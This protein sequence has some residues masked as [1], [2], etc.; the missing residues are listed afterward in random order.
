MTYIKM[1]HIQLLL[2]ATLLAV[3]LLP[4]R[5][6][7][8]P[9]SIASLRSFMSSSVIPPSTVGILLHTSLHRDTSGHSFSELAEALFPY[10][11]LTDGNARKLAEEFWAKKAVP[12]FVSTKSDH[13]STSR[14][15]TSC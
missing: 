5:L 4:L 12:N 10:A 14:L 15:A 11:P 7:V 2:M 1:K 8:L 6:L 3:T 9:G 13:F